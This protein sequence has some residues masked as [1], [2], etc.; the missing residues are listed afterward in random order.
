MSAQRAPNVL[1]LPRLFMRPIEVVRSHYRADVY[2][3]RIR[4]VRTSRAEFDWQLA[5][6][7]ASKRRRTRS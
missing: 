6:R 5:P 7:A 1:F 2:R 4:V 3:Y